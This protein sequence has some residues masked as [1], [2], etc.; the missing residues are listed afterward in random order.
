MLPCLTIE[1]SI[2]ATIEREQQAHA[3]YFV[4]AP[5]ALV[6][7]MA[8]EESDVDVPDNGGVPKIVLII[9]LVNLVVSGVVAFLVLTKEA[10]VVAAAP[11]VDAATD[12]PGPVYDMDPV[13]VNLAEEGKTRFLKLTFELEMKDQAALDKFV[14][15]ERAVRDALV[16]FLSSLTVKDTIGEQAKTDLQ[17]AI[18]A[19]IE[20]EA[21]EGLV[22]RVYFRDFVVQ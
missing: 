15:A 8:E 18:L 19:R 11:E 5:L 10:T 16:R 7:S 9:L 13:V 22:T 20:K 3:G 17:V 12:M 4:G 21:G 2:G 1:P 6:T 14:M